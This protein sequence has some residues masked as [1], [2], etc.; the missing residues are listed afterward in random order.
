MLPSKLQGPRSGLLSK[1]PSSENYTVTLSVVLF[2]VFVL[3]F[4]TF[5][6]TTTP[7]KQGSESGSHRPLP[8]H[9]VARVQVRFIPFNL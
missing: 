7:F 2:C 5:R 1:N 3:A 9:L 4:V 6:I 8:P